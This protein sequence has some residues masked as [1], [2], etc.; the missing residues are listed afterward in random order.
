MYD[1]IVIGGGMSGIMASIWLASK[2]RKV[3][4]VSKGDPMCCLSTGCIDVAGH[5]L[6]PLKGI[7]KLPS[8]HPYKL[9]GIDG[10]KNAI[11]FFKDLIEYSGLPYTGNLDENRQILTPLGTTKTTCLV[12]KTMEGEADPEEYVHVVSFKGLKDFYPSY[13]V[14][15]KK[16]SD[17]S[18][19]DMGVSSTMGLAT[20]FDDRKFLHRF[21]K[22]LKQL[23][24]PDG[25]IAIPAVLGIISPVSTMEEISRETERDIFEIPTLPPS[26]P[27]IRLYRRL[28][29]AA[30]EK[31][32]HMYL[33]NEIASIEKSGSRIEAVTLSSNSR[34]ARVSGNTFILATGSFIS[35]GLYATREA[36]AHETVFNLPVFMPK[37]RHRW[38]NEDFFIPGHPIE[39]AGI[40][41]DKS[42]RPKNCDFENL[43]VCGSIL[44]LSEIMKYQC[45]HGLAISTGIEA[46]KHCDGYLE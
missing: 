32:V 35:G 22:M 5:T 39:K 43:F 16:N 21:I 24:I 30:Q 23:E 42:F 7:N 34:P 45:G 44:A 8:R 4:I 6:K 10:I 3:A 14:S 18:T 19:F 31:G 17:F 15:R 2:G 1:T 33:G 25:K 41:V 12:P 20:H 37:K 29:W 38:F 26:I 11:D 27:G 13:I 28:K 46:A 40:L 36:H 9:V